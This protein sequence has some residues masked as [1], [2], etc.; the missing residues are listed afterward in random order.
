MSHGRTL[1]T[2]ASGWIGSR[3]AAVLPDLH[4]IPAQS[5]LDGSARATVTTGRHD[6]IVNAAG[7]RV[8][9]DSDLYAANVTLVKELI[10]IADRA[11][12]RI[13]HLGSAAE[14][15]PEHDGDLSEDVVPC[16]QSYY[17]LTKLLATELLSVRAD[18]TTLR[19]FNLAS[20][21][22]QAGSP[23]ADVVSRVTEAVGR[24]GPVELLAAATVRDWVS[25]YFVVRS[26]ERAV[27]APT[28]GVF[29]LC[30]A[31]GVSM[32]DLA[33]AMLGIL[34][35]EQ[36]GV[37]DLQA[38]PATTVVGDGARWRRETGLVERLGPDDIARL[39][40]DD[41]RAVSTP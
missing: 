36:L 33:E 37:R 14:Y 30:S 1:L 8:G 34:G 29:N 5:L 38:A 35:A 4:V 31:T 22:P 23:L 12:C 40:L 18:A 24:G 7:L 32:R 9:N 6:V 11:G 2:G 15:G 27:V 19:V 25:L 16:P 26:V 13:V 10:A 20:S 21:P 17:G 3:L 28:P 39:A 41:Q